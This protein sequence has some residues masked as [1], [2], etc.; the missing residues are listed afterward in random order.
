MRDHVGGAF[1]GSSSWTEYK[2]LYYMT[3]P[4]ALRGLGVACDPEQVRYAVSG[5]EPGTVERTLKPLPLVRTE[6]PVEAW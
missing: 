4:E 5:C 3:N 2:S 6:D 1:A